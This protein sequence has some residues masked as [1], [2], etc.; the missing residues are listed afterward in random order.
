MECARHDMNV[1]GRSHVTLLYLLL[2][3]TGYGKDN[4]IIFLPFFL[5]FKPN[6]HISC[7]GCV[8]RAS[9][10]RMLHSKE[11]MYECCAD[12]ARPPEEAAFAFLVF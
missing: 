10:P 7:T 6:I 3:Y 12:H 11:S 1:A 4:H 2:S 9:H 8:S 5:F